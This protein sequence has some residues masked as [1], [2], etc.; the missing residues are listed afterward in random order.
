[1][2]RVPVLVHFQNKETKD[3][4]V[5]LLPTPRQNNDIP[6]VLYGVENGM[7]IWNRALLMAG[8]SGLTQ[9]G[10]KKRV[11]QMLTH[12]LCALQ[13]PLLQEGNNGIMRDL[14]DPGGF[15][16]DSKASPSLPYTLC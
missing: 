14:R 5:H 15:V 16:G 8:G 10:M 11:G 3:N 1:M 7:E 4:Q 12:L 2:D 9:V 6:F 13:A